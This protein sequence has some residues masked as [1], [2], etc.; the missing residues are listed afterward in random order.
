MDDE[1]IAQFTSIT[2]ASPSQAA[3]YLSLADGHLEQA[4]QLFFENPDLASNTTA[5]TQPVSQPQQ[6]RG[7]RR[8]QSGYTEDDDGV[9]HLDSDDGEP[10]VDDED[11]DD[12]EMIGSNTIR[13]TVDEDA[14]AEMARRLQNEMYQSN[15]GM[16]ADT[17]RAPIERVRQTL[18]GGEYDYDD[19]DV[20]AMIQE[21]IHRSRQGASRKLTEL[22]FA[23]MH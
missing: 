22:C 19:A 11:D 2:S 21:R 18:V 9:I 12:V 4:I 15:S 23:A 7:S 16:E 14:D 6:S 13:Q 20:S 17:V 1:T 8:Q 3:Q 10:M 5:P